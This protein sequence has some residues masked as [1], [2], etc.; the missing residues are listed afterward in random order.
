MTAILSGS[1]PAGVPEDYY[2]TLAELAH[3]VSA[4]Y[5]WTPAEN[6]CGWH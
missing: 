3:N 2:A 5:S 1:L 4:A 6:H